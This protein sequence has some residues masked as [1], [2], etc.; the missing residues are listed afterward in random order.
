MYN[1]V[2]PSVEAE[3]GIV[4]LDFWKKKE[5]KKE[6]K[7]TEPQIDWEEVALYW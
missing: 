5:K 6:R 7:K 4:F 3:N 1:S 2:G